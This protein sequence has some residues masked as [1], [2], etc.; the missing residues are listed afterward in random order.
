[1]HS[2][3]ISIFYE[4]DNSFQWS[5]QNQVQNQIFGGAAVA[6]IAKNGLFERGDSNW[7]HAKEWIIFFNDFV[8]NM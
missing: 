2:K 1:M 8:W 3:D 4:N 6:F 5:S 7:A